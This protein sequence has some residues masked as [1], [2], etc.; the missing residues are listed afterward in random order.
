MEE[1][2][3][4]YIPF[5]DGMIILLEHHTRTHLQ[6]HHKWTQ[7]AVLTSDTEWVTFRD[8]NDKVVSRYQTRQEKGLY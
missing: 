1:L 3:F 5:I 7:E 2:F 4:V 8:I 6:I